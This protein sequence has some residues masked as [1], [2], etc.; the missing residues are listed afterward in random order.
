MGP[1]A[2]NTGF[3]EPPKQGTPAGRKQRASDWDIGML[4]RRDE[5]VRAVRDPRPSLITGA[6]T[7]PSSPTQPTTSPLGRPAF[8]AHTVTPAGEGHLVVAEADHGMHVPCRPTRLTDAPAP[9]RH[10]RLLCPREQ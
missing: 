7:P 5:P 4:T 10:E 1:N 6:G 3:H 8:R 9:R 2:P